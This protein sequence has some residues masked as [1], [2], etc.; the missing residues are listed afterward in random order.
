MFFGDAVPN[1]QLD[2]V[3]DSAI[4][5][6]LFPRRKTKSSRDSPK[7]ISPRIS[8]RIALGKQTVVASQTTTNAASNADCCR[9]VETVS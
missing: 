2:Q 7:H 9:T 3:Y 5:Q 4:M 8:H 6:A 1:A